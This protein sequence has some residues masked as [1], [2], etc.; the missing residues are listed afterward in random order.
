[1]RG[2]PHALPRSSLI[3]SD[4]PVGEPAVLLGVPVLDNYLA[5]VAGR[6]R[7]NTLLAVAQH[8]QVFFRTVGSPP[9]QVTSADVWGFVTAQ[10][11]CGPPQRVQPLGD[12][13][14]GESTSTLRRRLSS[15]S[16]LS[17]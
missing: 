4:N 7:P 15:V 3:R 5:F 6:C 12:V 1:M 10:R 11:T 2:D 13:G 17:G 9:E 14:G 8:L 16:G